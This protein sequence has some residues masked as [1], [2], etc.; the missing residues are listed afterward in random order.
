MI[1]QSTAKPVAWGMLH[2]ATV[3]KW[4]KSLPQSK[5]RINFY[6]LQRL[7][8]KQNKKTKKKQQQQQLRDKLLR[9]GVLHLVMFGA[10]CVWTLLWFVRFFFIEAVRFPLQ[11]NGVWRDTMFVVFI[12]LFNPLLNLNPTY[13]QRNC[14]HLYR[15]VLRY[16]PHF[17]SKEAKY[18]N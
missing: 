5:S 11:E 6:F 2:H 18:A 17:R 12:P 13:N 8:Q 3:K 15:G 10:T 4:I 14:L 16:C 9:L 1:E 7:R